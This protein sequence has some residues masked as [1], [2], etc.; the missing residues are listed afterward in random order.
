MDMSSH[1]RTLKS[2][3]DDD[4]TD[5]GQVLK[6]IASNILLFFLIFGMA[7]TV[8]VSNLRRQLKNRNAIL[9][10]IAMQFAIMPF[11]GFVAV[12]ILKDYGLTTPMGITLLIVTASPGGSYSNWWCSL[13]N[14]DLA[15]S[16]AMTALSTIL[17][18]ALL[19]AN[20]MLY[21]HM[22]YGFNN[23]SESI[24]DGTQNENTTNH[25]PL[26][27]IDFASLFIS[28]G[29]VIGAIFSGLLTSHKI[30]SNRFRKL[31][32][33]LG[34]IAGLA[35]ILVS[36]FFTTGE[37][38]KPWQQ[39]WS[40]YV[41]VG[42]PCIGGLIIANVISKFL[43]LENPEIVTLS[44]ECC[45]QNVGIAT[46]AVLAMFDG[47]HVAQAMAV[48]LFYGL[49][50][51]VVLGLYC[52]VAWKLGWTKAPSDD[53]LCKVLTMSY[54]VEDS[55]DE[56][57]DDDD[58]IHADF[59]SALK[60]RLASKNPIRSRLDTDDTALMST[61]TARSRLNTDDT[62]MALDRIKEKAILNQPCRQF[63]IIIE[64]TDATDQGSPVT[65][66][67]I[68]GDNGLSC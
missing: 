44:V 17:S 6:E 53:K 9:T 63:P 66:A 39:H 25:D 68:N 65:D 11:L 41:G 58:V 1:L 3:S 45:Y 8:N 2:V 27:S 32:N 37:N 67:S 23:S 35:L 34:S 18:V 60:K 59:P 12:I 21:A 14:A 33:R 46:S 40:F 61:Q 62:G 47:D 22:A 24:S 29:I 19:P 42:L 26:K 28:L 15:L 7:G 43:K 16:V 36:V 52:V 49:M 10:G 51:A 31:S 50:E 57:G 20:L 5:T 56:G 54:E 13:F 64:G 55:D 30:S 38:V 48:P 4:G